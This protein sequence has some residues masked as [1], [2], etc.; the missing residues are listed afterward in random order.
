MNNVFTF[1]EFT[2]V[3]DATNGT[4]VG[5]N[6]HVISEVKR[7]NELVGHCLSVF[8]GPD[9]TLI[10]ARVKV[11]ETSEWTDSADSYE[12]AFELFRAMQ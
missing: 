7:D 3:Y 1:G 12:E 4:M 8:E 10:N 5:P 6:L 11:W 2:M 9:A